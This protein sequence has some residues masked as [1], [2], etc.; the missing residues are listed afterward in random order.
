MS[1][2]IINSAKDIL[3]SAETTGLKNRIGQQINDV[4]TILENI[5]ASQEYIDGA[6]SRLGSVEDEKELSEAIQREITK[7]NMLSLQE[8]GED[9][10]D[11]LGKGPKDALGKGAKFNKPVKTKGNAKKSLED[12]KKGRTVEHLEALFSGEDLTQ[13]FKDKAAAIF[14]AA[15]NARVEEIQS[16]LIRQSRDVFVEEVTSVRETLTAK[17]DDYLNYVVSEW[18]SENELA[19]ESGIQTEISESFMRGLRGL[20]ESHYIEVPES[21][22]NVLDGM[23]DKNRD[24]KVKLN[25]AIKENV[26]LKKKNTKANCGSIFE[27]LSHGLAATEVEKFKSLARGIEYNTEDEFASKLNIIKEN[28]F[29]NNNAKPLQNLNEDSYT[30]SNGHVTSPEG[31][32]PRMNAYF[33]AVGRLSDSAENNK[34]L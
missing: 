12:K 17:M 25:K 4:A 10:E 11:A 34:Q 15:I 31:L 33:D 14:E 18:M 7:A 30:S 2:S 5:G 8:S 26:Q 1:N 29:N 27:Q 6:F 20:F 21:K 19:I 13:E 24:L 3:E 23:V 22:V 28:Y 32:N 16:E 9:E